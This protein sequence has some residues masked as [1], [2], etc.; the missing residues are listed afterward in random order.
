MSSDANF[1]GSRYAMTRGTMSVTMSAALTAWA[2]D[3]AE[4]LL[5]ANRRVPWW[6]H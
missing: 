5:A 3:R 4:R 2:D 6:L 1:L